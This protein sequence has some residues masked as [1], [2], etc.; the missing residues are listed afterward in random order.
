MDI[1]NECFA[2]TKKGGRRKTV[3]S[4]RAY[5]N[6]PYEIAKKLRR[7]QMN[8]EET[9]ESGQ[10]SSKVY[11]SVNINTAIMGIKNL[12]MDITGDKRSI[13]R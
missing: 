6:T 4:R 10:W 1:H 13:R 12:I 8:L 9:V 5:V 7:I 11:P 2:S 3:S